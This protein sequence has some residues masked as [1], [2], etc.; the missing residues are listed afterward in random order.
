MDV[1]PEVIM[2]QFVIY[3]RASDYPQFEYVC[4]KW[5]IYRDIPAPVPDPQLT[6]AAHDDAGLDL[7]RLGLEFR[8]LTRLPRDP[9]DD[10]AILEIW[11]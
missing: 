9:N 7:M 3:R 10:P 1:E 6:G 8:G 5:A 2:E 4:R 11:I